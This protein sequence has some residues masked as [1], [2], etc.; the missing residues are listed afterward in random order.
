MSVMFVIPLKGAQSG[1]NSYK[2]DRVHV[3]RVNPYSDLDAL[4]DV[5]ETY[6]EPT[7]S[8]YKEQENLRWWLSEPNGYM[9]QY[10]VRYGDE[11]DIFWN[12]IYR[13]VTAKTIS[14]VPN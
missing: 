10:V 11:T 13:K 1:L 4:A 7:I 8:D 5:P 14:L 2:L 3:F 12:E 9:G 6:E